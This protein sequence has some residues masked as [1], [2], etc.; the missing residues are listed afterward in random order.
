MDNKYWKKKD[1]VGYEPINPIMCPRCGDEMVLRHS[2]HHVTGHMYLSYKCPSC[3]RFLRFVPSFI[4]GY[5]L[6]YMKKVF[7]QRGEKTFLVPV[8]KWL[9]N[10]KIKEKLESLGDW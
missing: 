1:V 6:K 2:A 7:K 8:D 4:C 3:D 9:E 5:D 10:E